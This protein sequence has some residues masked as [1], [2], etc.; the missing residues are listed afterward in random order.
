MKK[1]NEIQININ[2][3]D[4]SRYIEAAGERK[5]VASEILLSLS[6]FNAYSKREKIKLKMRNWMKLNKY[7]VIIIWKMLVL[8]FHVRHIKCSIYLYVWFVDFC[9][10]LEYSLNQ[11]NFYCNLR[12][13]PVSFNKA[14]RAYKK[15]IC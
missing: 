6:L 4:Y 5:K 15:I 11:R 1:K 3:I 10:V 14:F 12:I 7:D 8:K 13:S 9:K 2:V